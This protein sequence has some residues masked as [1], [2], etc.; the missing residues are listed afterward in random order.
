MAGTP[1]PQQLLDHLHLWQIP[2]VETSGW[3]D[4]CRCHDG[5]HERGERPRSGNPFGPVEEVTD[6]ITA[7]D[8][9]GRAPLTYVFNILINDPVVPCKANFAI[10]PDGAVYLISAGRTNH[11][12]YMSPAALTAIRNGTFSLDHYDDKR[13][14]GVDPKRLSYGI[15]V[16]AAS[17]MNAKQRASLIR[18]NAC[19]CSLIKTNGRNVVGHGEV[20]KDRSSADPNENMGFVR[21][22]TMAAVAAGPQ[23]DDPLATWTRAELKDVVNETVIELCR[24]PEFKKIVA[25]AVLNYEVAYVEPNTGEVS[26]ASKPN[27]TLGVVTTWLERM[28]VGN[29]NSVVE[30]LTPDA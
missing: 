2:L 16:I 21:R 9:N 1:T 8:L 19:L 28:I 14:E 5:S 15:E 29:G 13:G 12:L 26:P 17:K 20:A 24:S 18:L 23:E 6:H 27:Q 10:D 22:D 7:G 11:D 4:R 30:R 25:E 3:R